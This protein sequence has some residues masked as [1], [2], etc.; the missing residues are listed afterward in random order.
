MHVLWR[1]WDLGSAS[2]LEEDAAAVRT[3]YHIDPSTP[4]LSADGGFHTDAAK[5]VLARYGPDLFLESAG[6]A[7]YLFLTPRAL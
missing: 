4:L 7:I 1:R 3:L 6:G 2:A 5:A